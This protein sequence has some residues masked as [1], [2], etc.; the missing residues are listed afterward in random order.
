MSIEIDSCAR[1][2]AEALEE[3][4]E[5]MAFA[6]ALPDEYATQDILEPFWARI[7]VMVTGLSGVVLVLDQALAVQLSDLLYVEDEGEQPQEGLVAELANVLTGRMLLACNESGF[8]LD[9][10][11]K[12][13]GMPVFAQSARHLGFRVDDEHPLLIVLETDAA[14]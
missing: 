5:A 13:R 2:I 14:E 11:Q 1:I 4:L 8:Q 7:P 10:P 9:V 12:G 6:Q 3:T